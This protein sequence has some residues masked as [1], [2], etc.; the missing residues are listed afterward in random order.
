[1]KQTDYMRGLTKAEESYQQY[2]NID[3]L[4]ANL[5]SLFAV[6]AKNPSTRIFNMDYVMGYQ[7]FIQNKR[8]NA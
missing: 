8:G 4:E 6:L 1:M 5:K 2:A 7:D 3:L